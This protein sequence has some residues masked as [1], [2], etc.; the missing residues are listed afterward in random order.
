LKT[1]LL[2]LGRGLWETVSEVP[3]W[4]D[5]PRLL[6]IW[7]AVPVLLPCTVALVF[8]GWE[9]LVREPGREEQRRAHSHLLTL[10]QDVA[11]LRLSCS[12][13]QAAE[14]SSRAAE[15]LGLVLAGPDEA[16]TW[17]R[18]LREPLA[19]LGWQVT[20]QS[21]DSAAT[22]EAPGEQAV[23]F[24]PALIRLNATE[25]NTQTLPSL[26]AALERLTNADRR[27]DLTRLNVRVDES[28]KAAAEINLRVALRPDHEK[29][30]Q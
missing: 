25:A 17:L 14:L 7:R 10:E 13:Q 28:G 4:P 26:L 3:G 19:A 12:E 24:A 6:R 1:D 2:R 20:I 5:A 23:L 11:D 29:A 27:I 30:A 15:V 18:T 8:W 21:Y 9:G 22:G 16:A